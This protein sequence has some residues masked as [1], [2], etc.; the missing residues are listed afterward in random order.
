MRFSAA[1][2]SACL[3]LAFMGGIQSTWAQD[4][5]FAQTTAPTAQAT[6][7]EASWQSLHMGTLVTA[8]VF[9]QTPDEVKRLGAIVESEIVRFDDMM[10]VHKETALNEVNRSAGE[11]VEVTPEIAEMTR[12][13]LEV[14]DLTDSAF[15]PTIG[16]IVNLWKIGFGG[17]SVPSD[18]AIAEALKHV[19]HRTVALKE[20]DGR[21][22]LRIEKGQNID[23]GAI[24]HARNTGRFPLHDVFLLPLITGNSTAQG[25]T[26]WRVFQSSPLLQKEMAS[27]KVLGYWGGGSMQIMTKEKPVTKLEDMKGLRMTCMS[28]PFA[29]AVQALDANPITVPLPDIY[30]TLSRNSAD[31]ALFSLLASG[32]IKIQDIIKHITLVSL[33]KDIRFVGIN[34]DLWDSFPPDIQK[35]I[36]STCCSESWAARMSGVMD[37]GDVSGRELLTKAGA[38]FYTLDDAEYERWVKACA[39]LDQAWINKVVELGIAEKDARALL[40]QV[41]KVGAEVTNSLSKPR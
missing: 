18:A 17:H 32:S 3:S 1:V 39:P 36:E 12:E 37:E 30:M 28:K 31:S 19:N 27:V 33:C 23:M 29:D 7:Y 14:A 8:K 4:N 41:R 34:K 16:P 25:V 35:A 13:A 9:G 15:E 24:D 26:A 38:K 11:W 10:S 2:L 5:V 20:E 40:E 6:E 22:F 21:H